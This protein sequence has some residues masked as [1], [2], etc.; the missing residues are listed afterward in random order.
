MHVKQ[1]LGVMGLVDHPETPKL[2]VIAH[3]NGHTCK[4][5][6]F[7]CRSSLKSTNCHIP[8]KSPQ[9]PKTMG[10]SSRK[11]PEN[12]KMMSFWSCLSSMY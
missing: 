3:E 6:K 11:W 8:C 5:D 10:N 1:V 4:N 9:N 2:W 12:A 7:F